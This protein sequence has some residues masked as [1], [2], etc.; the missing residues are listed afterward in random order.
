MSLDRI[1]LALDTSDR[2]QAEKWARD[3]GGRGRIGGMKIGLQSFIAREGGFPFVETISK[4]TPSIFLDL[5]LHDI[6]NT[7]KGACK[8]L[9]Q[10]P[11][12]F[13]TFHLAAGIQAIEMIERE[14]KESGAGFEWV[15]VSVLTSFSEESFQ[16]WTHTSSGLVDISSHWIE[17]ALK[18]GINTF[19]CSAVDLEVLHSRFP[20]AKWIVPGIRLKSDPLDDQAR[21]MSPQEAFDRGADF[22]VMGRSLTSKEPAAAIQELITELH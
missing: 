3:F 10:S 19:V 7:M 18:T 15:G 4:L 6:P 11:I 20:Q 5:K 2:V 8:S 9:A 21:V 1:F 13:V 17:Q 16:K 12:K 14:R 22:L